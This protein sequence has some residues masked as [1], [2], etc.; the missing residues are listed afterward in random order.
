M[1]DLLR[2]PE[3]A[4]RLRL[5]HRFVRD[6]LMRGNLRG[7]RIGGQWLVKPADLDAY[8]EAHANVRAAKS[9]ARR[10]S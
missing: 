1:T 3:V 9:R 8:I 6:E 7:S 2:V 10:A 4:E 5:G